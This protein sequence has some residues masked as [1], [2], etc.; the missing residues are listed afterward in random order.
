[1]FG[2]LVE[3]RAQIPFPGLGI[4]SDNG[5]EFINHH[6]FNWCTDQQITFTRSRPNNSNDGAHVEQKNWGVVRRPPAGATTHR[7]RWRP[8]PDLD[9]ALAADQ[10]VHP[11]TKA[12]LQDPGRREGDRDLR[13]R[14]D[15][16]ERLLEHADLLDPIDLELLAKRL[17][18]TNPAQLRREVTDLQTTLLVW[19]PTTTPPAEASRTPPT[20]PG[21]T[22]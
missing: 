17:Q 8:E 15:P 7:A 10:P 19:S 20:S 13:H 1:V 3:I 2:A 22:G 18:T 5:S 21:Q 12:G 4:D 11:A 16:Y 6:L 9:R 14:Q